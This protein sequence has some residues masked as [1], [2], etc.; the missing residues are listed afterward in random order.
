MK[1]EKQKIEQKHK[2]DTTDLCFDTIKKG[3]QA[4]VFV[5]TK[6]SAE[7]TAEDIAGNIKLKDED[8]KKLEELSEK[9][10]DALGKPTRQCER[11]SY[12]VKKGIAFHHAGL[13][14][15]QR[16]LIEDN[17][18]SGAIKIICCT[19]TLAF[20]LDL[21]A[22]RAI[23]KDLRR[24][25][26]RGLQFIPVLEYQQMSGRAG[27]PKF[28]S[29]GE[30][31]AVASSSAAKKE[32]HSRYILGDVE[33]IY[34]KLA[35]EPVLRIYLLSLIASNFLN[36][37]SDIMKFF[38]KTFWAFQFKDMDKLEFIIDKMLSMLEEWNFLK[39]SKIEDFISANQLFEDKKY[40]A[41]V[42]GK[43]VSELYIDPLTAHNFVLGLKNAEKMPVNAFSFLQLI[44]NTMELK[45]LLNVKVREFDEIQEFL[46]KNEEFLL[47]K[48]PSMYYEDHDEFMNSVKTAMFF[49]DWINE[50]DEEY[51]LEKYSIRPGE[52]RVKLEAADWLIYAIEEISK[53][54]GLKKIIS[55][56][57]R[58]R[59]RIKYGVKEELLALL[60]LKDI[61]RVRARKLFKNGI[62]DI[63]DVK[64]AD[65]STLTQILG[66]NIAIK[67]K[68]QLGDKI[69]EVPK[70]KRKGQISLQ[71][72]DKD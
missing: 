7:K 16:E 3:K 71:K 31:I 46:V 61:G 38:S 65:I 28:D 72:Y 19:P 32:L 24:Y 35:V 13:A 52:I 69:E 42:V 27:R 30:S 10:L 50:N 51:L 26:R 21:P 70:G 12:C 29:H 64:K 15:S 63:S 5:N 34:S 54:T 23:M 37:K 60:K 9:I 49:R 59:V 57:I 44:S 25:G 41:T 36:T 2:D 8:V 48:E 6:N 33:N 22:F 53:I 43:R 14:H 11:L 66:K 68:E 18:R 58:L 20:G 67:I 1:N 4:L 17:F 45:P 40:E 62:K 39:S 56:I 47:E 55:D